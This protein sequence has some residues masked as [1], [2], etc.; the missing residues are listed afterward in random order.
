MRFDNVRK[1]IKQDEGLR[2]KPY[3]DTE[4]KL[5]I[6]YGH[7]L[8][9]VGLREVEADF[10]FD[11]DFQAAFDECCKFPWFKTLDAVRQDVIICM[12]FNLGPY[13]FSGFKRMIAAVDSGYFHIAAEEMIKSR[14]YAQVGARATEL[15]L[16]METGSYPDG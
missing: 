6:G 3:R 11:N 10:I 16:M 12:M 1:K 4:G 15:A 7:N 8:D 5:T 2:L 9:D 14:W 13:K